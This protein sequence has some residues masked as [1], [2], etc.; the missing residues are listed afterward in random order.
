VL[1]NYSSGTLAVSNATIDITGGM[2]GGTITPTNSTL[3]I[4]GQMSGGN[5][6]LSSS[7]VMIGTGNPSI[8]S[9]TGGGSTITYGSGAD[10][11]YLVNITS[12]GNKSPQLVNFNNNDSIGE[13]NIPFNSAT[14]TGTG[15]NYTITLKMG[16]TTVA[17]FNNVTLASGAS[18]NFEPVTTQV[19]G[20]TTYYVATLDPPT[21]PVGS[22]DTS[23]PT[24]G[25]DPSGATSPARNDPLWAPINPNTLLG[26]FGTTRAGFLQST[27]SASV[28][29]GQGQGNEHGMKH[30]LAGLM[31]DLT[32]FGSLVSALR[33]GNDPLAGAGSQTPQI[34]GIGAALNNP[35]QG[36]RQQLNNLVK[37]DDHKF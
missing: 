29:L 20:G 35:D 6:T 28:S 14:L 32:N 2:S 16:A 25:A 9:V 37:P 5:V 19:I 3:V 13:S 8:P 4:G 24:G 30:L 23:R 26:S 10:A 36:E 33:H 22:T 1:S 21:L 17:T 18:H 12:G 7:T 31:S 27:G 15:P 34:T 11:A